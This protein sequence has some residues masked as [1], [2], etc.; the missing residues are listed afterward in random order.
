[1]ELFFNVQWL[2]KE[3]KIDTRN[4][5]NAGNLYTEYFCHVNNV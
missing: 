5:M 4:S 3:F 2:T 1:M